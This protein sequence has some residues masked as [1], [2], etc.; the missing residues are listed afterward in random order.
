MTRP[1]GDDR[2]LL[3][4]IDGG[5]IRGIIPAT[6]L[7]ALE[8][9][10]GRLTRETF[11]FVAGTSTGAIITAGVVAGIPAERILD[12]YLTRAQE[13]FTKG[14]LNLPRRIVLGSMYSTDRLRDV[15]A[16]ALG[17]SR[18]WRL[19]DS[20]IDLLITAKRLTDGMPWYFVRDDPANAGRTGHLRLVD[21][22]VASA[23]APTYFP[24]Y[25]VEGVGRLV[26]GGIGVAGNPV[27]QACVEAFYYTRR[28][29]P[30]RTTIVSL[31]T[32]RFPAPGTPTWLW[33]WLEW[34]IGE[35]L[36]SPGEQQTEI[37]RRHFPEA[38]FYRIDPVLD[39]PVA[40]D[41]VEQIDLLR[42]YGERLA[43]Q[44]DWQAILRGDEAAGC[45]SDENTL[46]PQD[47]RRLS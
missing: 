3:L 26:D 22:A 43:A 35:L 23:A 12:L 24:P 8:R 2:R 27:Y 28:Y 7:V 25:S 29:Q 9:V 10:T 16:N 21:C 6:L 45:V 41:G 30:G 13:V 4:A 15:V 46:W 11:S 19:N 37:V 44:V 14:P 42:A 34:V 20:P 1:G 5:G 40:L 36:R 18:D 31:G 33:P 17:S 39:R 38:P 32:G 47:A